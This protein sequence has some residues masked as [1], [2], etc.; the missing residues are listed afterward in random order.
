MEAPGLVHKEQSSG[1]KPVQEKSP[2]VYAVLINS[3]R[4]IPNR[5]KFVTT[6]EQAQKYLGDFDPSSYTMYVL[7][8]LMVRHKANQVYLNRVVGSAAAKATG[9][10]TETTSGVDNTIEFELQSPGTD[11]DNFELVITK[12]PLRDE[13]EVSL[14]A[15]MNGDRFEV[16][17][18]DGLKSDP[19][20]AKYIPTFLNTNCDWLTVTDNIS[21]KASFDGEF[22]S[23]DSVTVT[24]SGGA[25]DAPKL[26]DYQGSFSNKTGVYAFDGEGSIRTLLV[27]D[28]VNV[29]DSGDAAAQDQLDTAMVSY[30]DNKDYMIYVTVTP[31]GENAQTAKTTILDTWALDSKNLAVYWNWIK[32]TDPL[33]GYEK[34]I[35]P[36][37]DDAGV[38][39]DVDSGEEGV[40]KAPANES[41]HGVIGLEFEDV[42]TGE[43]KLLND[44]GINANIKSN[45]YRVMGARLRTSDPEWKYIH[46]RRTY[47]KHA[48]SIMGSLSWA[49]FEVKD[50]GSGGLYGKITRI[51]NNYFRKEDRRIVP[52]GSLRNKKNPTEK[53]YYVVC[54]NQNNQ[55]EG[56]VN[57]DWGISIVDTAEVI[58]VRSR[59][60][61]GGAET[62]IV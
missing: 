62:I 1:N 43:H 16:Y 52:N 50:G 6:F 49:L 7:Q 56:V 45:G 58:R 36:H 3:K 54:N 42:T 14:T 57:V 18:T 61:D 13:Y 12:N 51:I 4:G 41:L 55:E 25:D 40:H 15:L 22:S 32:V 33:T 59:Q 5:R 46:K 21:D 38:W 44:V 60:W 8:Q 31:Q 47:F 11:G 20:D 28:N 29:K 19:N 17:G 53:P 27:P 2:S 39:A 26:T 10:L 48:S 30:V 24:F 35:P 23:V 34:L 37:G 9:T